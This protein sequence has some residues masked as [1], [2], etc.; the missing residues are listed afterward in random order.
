[1]FQKAFNLVQSLIALEKSEK[2]NGKK[3]Y[4]KNTKKMETIPQNF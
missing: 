3:N 1:M 2:I 4:K